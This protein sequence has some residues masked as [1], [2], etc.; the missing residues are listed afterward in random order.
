[1]V[2]MGAI[3]SAIDRKKQERS[4]ERMEEAGIDPAKYV[5]DDTPPPDFPSSGESTIFFQ[6]VPQSYIKK[7]MN[8]KFRVANRDK[9]SWVERTELPSYSPDSVKALY[10][11]EAFQKAKQLIKA[12]VKGDTDALGD[13]A[14]KA[15]K[16][17]GL[18]GSH[19]GRRLG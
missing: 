1:M 4:T 12:V 5:R 18:V 2:V 9:M 16:R 6:R 7:H 3:Q 19:R 17:G 8:A 10:G 11:D 13:M 14:D 15:F